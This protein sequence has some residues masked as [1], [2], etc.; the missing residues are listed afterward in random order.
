ML[1]SKQTS[2]WGSLGVRGLN[3]HR[4]DLRW[5]QACV[6]WSACAATSSNPW[7][8][9]GCRG[10]W[11]WARG[12]R[13]RWPARCLSSR[14]CS[15][16][17]S[18]WPAHRSTS[19]RSLCA[20]SQ[21]ARPTFC[22]LWLWSAR[23]CRGWWQLWSCPAPRCWPSPPGAAFRTAG[24]RRRLPR[25]TWWCSTASGQDCP[26]DPSCYWCSLHDLCGG[27]VEHSWA[28]MRRADTWHK[29]P[30][31][32]LNVHPPLPACP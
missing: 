8:G 31:R 1:S 7:G 22:R 28:E 5:P 25:Q 21:G 29:P 24:S 27:Q 10:S 13:S 16:S 2:H 15:T 23:G 17:P 20:L 3:R 32:S 11:R 19:C 18:C 30:T 14:C 9:S 26:S 6:S 12:Q 4:A